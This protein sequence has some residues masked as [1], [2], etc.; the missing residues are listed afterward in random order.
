MELTIKYALVRDVARGN[1][2]LGVNTHVDV[3]R[4]DCINLTVVLKH[5]LGKFEHVFW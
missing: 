5:N 3:C 4:Q 1:R 2:E